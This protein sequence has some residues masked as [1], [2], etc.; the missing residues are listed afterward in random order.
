[1]ALALASV[2]AVSAGADPPSVASAAPSAGPLAPARPFPPEVYQARRSKLMK[3]LGGG[4]AVLQARGE[5]DPDG[6]RQD[7]D[8][9]YLTGLNEPGAVLVLSPEERVYK[10]RL[11]LKPRDPDDERW[12]GVRPD[13]SDSLRRSTGIESISRTTF[14][15]GSL[16]GLLRTTRTLH[17]IGDPGGPDSPAPPEMTLYGKLT[18]RLPG[19]GIKDRT[20]LL[21]A[22]RSVK[23]PR[24]LDFME[25]AIAATAAAHRVAARAIRPGVEENW[26]A[27]LIDL[28]FKRG[29]AV[30]PAF[31]PIVGSGAS[32]TIL[33]YPEH[34]RTIAA[35]SL[36]VVDIG[37]DYGRYAA[38]VTRTYP[39]DGRFTPEQR[40]VYDVVLHAQQTCIDMIRPGVYYEDLQ[41]KAEEIIR[42][43]GY[44]DYFI[45]G[46]GHFVGLDVHDSGLYKKPLQAGMVLTVEPGIY[47]PEKSLGVRIEDEVLVTSKGHRLLTAALPRDADAVER[48]MRE[49]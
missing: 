5:E 34:S 21:P 33:H 40:R 7:G 4:I 8:F 26:V 31:P 22:M 12:T 18:S 17:L 11:F 49:P 48:M 19:V 16:M 32:S 23:E 20:D 45:H 1:M 43:A 46:L 13:I 10:E 37:S 36:V 41:R 38:D 14:L 24:E 2:P 3:A 39:A 27:G 44:R 30:R 15:G 35:G 42:E 47:I 6:Y 28:E 9:Y 29:G 25:K